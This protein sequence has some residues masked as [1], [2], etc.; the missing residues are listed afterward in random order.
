VDE[1]QLEDIEHFFSS[2]NLAQGREF[3]ITGRGGARQA[4]KMF[5]DAVSEFEQS[6]GK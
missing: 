1:Q 2:Y 6:K 5:R 3:R 4:Q